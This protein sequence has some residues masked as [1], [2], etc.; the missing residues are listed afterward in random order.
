MP[1]TSV[2]STGAV[3]RWRRMSSPARGRYSSSWCPGRE[4]S[5]YQL[6]FL[7]RKSGEFSTSDGRA[8]R[9]GP[10]RS[11]AIRQHG[12]SMVIVDPSPGPGVMPA[13]PQRPSR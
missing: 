1:L 3:T 13:M 5:R 9:S 6:P 10:Y 7:S 2:S 11:W 8:S 4:R 12:W